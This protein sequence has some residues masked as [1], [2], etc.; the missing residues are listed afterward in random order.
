[1]DFVTLGPEAVKAIQHLLDRQVEESDISMSDCASRTD[2]NALMTEADEDGI[3]YECPCTESSHNKDD[4][5][6]LLC[7]CLRCKECLI[8]EI[9]IGLERNSWPPQCQE[10]RID[11][12]FNL[13]RAQLPTHMVRSWAEVRQEYDDPQPVYCATPDCSLYLP[14]SAYTQDNKWAN[15][16]KCNLKTC[17]TCNSLRS[18]HSD[19][20]KCPDVIEPES[21]AEMRKQGYKPCPWCKQMIERDSGCDHMHCDRCGKNFCYNCGRKKG[22]SELPCN[23]SGEHAWVDDDMRDMDPEAQQDILDR[24]QNGMNLPAGFNNLHDLELLPQGQFRG[25]GRRVGEDGDE[26]ADIDQG[27][28]DVRDQ[29]HEEQQPPAGFNHFDAMNEMQRNQ[30]DRF[31]GV[32]F[33]G[34]GRRLGEQEGINDDEIPNDVAGDNADW[35]RLPAYQQPQPRHVNYHNFRGQGRR[36]DNPADDMSSDEEDNDGEDDTTS[37]M[38]EMDDE[39]PHDNQSYTD[40]GYYGQGR[41]LDEATNEPSIAEIDDT[42]DH[43]NSLH[44][45][46]DTGA[47]RLRR[48]NIVRLGQQAT[49]FGNN[50]NIPHAY[51]FRG[52]GRTLADATADQNGNMNPDPAVVPPRARH[53]RQRG[54]GH[55]RGNFGRHYFRG[56]GQRLGD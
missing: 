5:F 1:M 10:C 20:G 25:L 42:A 2:E 4:F 43:Q 46:M 52:L 24:I 56:Q 39:W 9:A 23:C 19:A 13:V 55:H 48:V 37:Q 41:R 29:A 28:D 17:T 38:D 35:G 27:D 21:L 34:Q 54:R 6:E 33:H 51:H 36:L 14:K 53:P 16:S 40:F 44:T 50:E 18:W 22:R 31:A 3:S 49:I 12:P 32:R 8:T 30:F 7:N 45:R 26:P 47:P 15:C 11:I